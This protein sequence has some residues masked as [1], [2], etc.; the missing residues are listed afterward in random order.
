MSEK[1]RNNNNSSGR[2]LSSRHTDG[3]KKRGGK[4]ASFRVTETKKTQLLFLLCVLLK[5]LHY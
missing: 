4:A 1:W 5:Q 3:G 2:A